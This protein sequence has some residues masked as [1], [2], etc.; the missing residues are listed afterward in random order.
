MKLIFFYLFV[1]VD[2]SLL[3][4]SANCYISVGRVTLTPFVDMSDCRRYSK[5]EEQAEQHCD[6]PIRIIT[7]NILISKT[8]LNRFFHHSHLTSRSNILFISNIYCLLNNW[9]ANSTRTTIVTLIILMASAAT[10]SVDVDRDALESP[11]LRGQL[12]I[13]VL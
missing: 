1:E 11:Q 13:D 7:P 6:V 10:T 8:I 12:P 2:I 9:Q 3:L 4:K 5:S